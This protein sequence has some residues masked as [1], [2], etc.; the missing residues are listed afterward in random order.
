MKIINGICRYI[1]DSK[2]FATI[3]VE[4]FLDSGDTGIGAAPRGSTTGRYDI[5]YNEY[6]PRGNNFSPIPDG[7]IEFFRFYN[8]CSG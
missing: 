2:G 1:F 5:Q 4:I 6:Y 7:H 3:E 8:I